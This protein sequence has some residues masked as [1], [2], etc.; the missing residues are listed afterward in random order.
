MPPFEYFYCIGVIFL[1]IQIKNALPSDALS[2]LNYLKQVGS[3]TDNLT[4]GAEGV[5]FSEKEEAEYIARFEG[6]KDNVMLLAKTEEKI[7]G[8]ATLSRF[9]NRM[10][11]R[12]EFGISVLK[13]YWNKKIG[14]A[15]L[16][17]IIDFAKENSFEIIDLNVRSDNYAAIHLYEKFGFEKICTYPN[18]FKIKNVSI[19]FDFMRLSIK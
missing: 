9:G 4:F 19:D 14:S 18:F 6:S 1:N 11:H 7:I 17:E 16:K 3:E 2:I 8:I 15:L 12:G 10:S 5:P 13:E